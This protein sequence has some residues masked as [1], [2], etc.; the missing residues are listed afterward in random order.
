MNV[1]GELRFRFGSMRQARTLHAEINQLRKRNKS[2]ERQLDLMERSQISIN[3]NNVVWIFGTGR[4]GSSWLW[5][6]LTSHQGHFGWNESYVGTM[7]RPLQSAT[8]LIKRDATI[9]G[10]SHREAWRESLSQMILRC[11]ASRFPE[12]GSSDLLFIKEPNGSLSAPWLSEAMPTSRIVVLARDPRDV[13]ASAIDSVKPG[14]WRTYSGDSKLS[15]EQLTQRRAEVYRD[16]MNASL[17][18]LSEHEGPKGLV[19]YEELIRDTLR[20]VDNLQQELGLKHITDST[21]AVQEHS[22]E[23]VPEQKKGEGR[24]MRKAT[25]GSWREDLSEAQV[26]TVEEVTH[27]LMERLGYARV[28]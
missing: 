27:P 28:T 1:L 2:L 18:S 15:L 14:A 12:M 23:N 20:C 19:S 17:K 11:A 8:N 22:W 16:H 7:L 24:A 13:V 25:P 4:S 26:R 5:R 6:I 21:Q 9:F 3:P 10:Y